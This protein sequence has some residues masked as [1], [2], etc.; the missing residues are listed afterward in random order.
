MAFRAQDSLG[1][2]R[3]LGVPVVLQYATNT[4]DVNGVPG[5]GNFKQKG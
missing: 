3:P 5:K 2:F 4:G 1:Q